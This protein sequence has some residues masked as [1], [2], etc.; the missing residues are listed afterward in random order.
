MDNNGS[1]GITVSGGHPELIGPETF[2]FSTL[3]YDLLYESTELYFT[4][5]HFE[6]KKTRALSAFTSSR[7]YTGLTRL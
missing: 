1:P 3:C 2:V 5:L 4:V 7:A 6:L